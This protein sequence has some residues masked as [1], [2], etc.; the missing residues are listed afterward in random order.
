MGPP[1]ALQSNSIVP[2]SPVMYAN[3]VMESIQVTSTH[4]EP[5]VLII[6]Q[7]TQNLYKLLPCIVGIQQPYLMHS[8]NVYIDFFKPTKGS[9]AV[10]PLNSVLFME[11][12]ILKNCIISIFSASQ[13]APIF[14]YDNFKILQMPC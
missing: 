5:G 3:L 9:D 2:I 12:I 6:A 14:H 11:N 13:I 1:F 7:I 8:V 4:P 10:E